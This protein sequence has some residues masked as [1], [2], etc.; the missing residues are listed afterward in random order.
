MVLCRFSFDNI[1]CVRFEKI[2]YYYVI[3]WVE[4]GCGYKSS[5]LNYVAAS[6]H[7]I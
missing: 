7:N 4:R 6:I 3:I 5:N 2:V 1:G